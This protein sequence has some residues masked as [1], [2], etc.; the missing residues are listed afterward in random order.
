MAGLIWGPR[1]GRLH[2]HIDICTS[3]FIFIQ[4]RLKDYFY[5]DSSKVVMCIEWYIVLQHNIWVGMA[6]L[7]DSSAGGSKDVGGTLSSQA[8]N[9]T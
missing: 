1:R 5:F 7:R 8:G 4:K 6:I 9:K 3:I 2:E